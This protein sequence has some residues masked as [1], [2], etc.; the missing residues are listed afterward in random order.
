MR[1]II[2]GGT[3]LIG[4]RL[5]ERMAGAGHEVIVLSRSPNRYA[6]MFEHDV[7]IEGWDARTAEGW[8]YLADGADVIVNLAGASIAGDG[9]PPSRWTPSR[10][11]LILES[12]LGAGNAVVEAIRAAEN[13]PG[14]VIQS[15]AIGY[16]GV[17]GD[18]KITEIALSGDDFL[19]RVCEKW[20]ASTAE[21][22]DMGVRQV[23]VR[24]GLVLSTEGGA[25]PIILMPIKLFVGGPL[26]SGEQYYSWIHID[27]VVGALRF[28][29]EHEDASGPFNLTA[30]NPKTNKEFVKTV[31]GVLGRPA[32]FPTP[33]FALRTALGEVATVVLDGQRVIPKKLLNMGYEFKFE[34]LEPAVRDLL[35]GNSHQSAPAS[36]AV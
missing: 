33:G 5:A 19:S 10:K 18:E 22:T 36:Q 35:E 14:L 7:H 28:L 23:A 21:V 6:G 4:S 11:R 2:T 1:V 15:S 8:G 34:E 16:Y 27:D 13:K 32:I 17:R 26:G 29:L 9:F 24:T 31:A 3:G 20:E 25:F 30:P 12:R